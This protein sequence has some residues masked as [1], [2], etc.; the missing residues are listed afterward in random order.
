[1]KPTP[2][3]AALPEIKGK[4]L[5]Y[6]FETHSAMNTSQ[7]NGKT[8]T[9]YEEFYE[10]IRLV[11]KEIT[12]IDTIS[13]LDRFCEEWGLNENDFDFDLSFYNLAAKYLKVTA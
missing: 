2:F 8:E 3:E 7:V 11:I 4:L 1:M 6:F 9:D 13:D 5:H 12:N 10:E